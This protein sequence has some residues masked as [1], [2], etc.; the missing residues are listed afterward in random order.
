MERLVTRYMLLAG[1]REK[2][3]P[4]GQSSSTRIGELKLDLDLDVEVLSLGLVLIPLHL[5]QSWIGRPKIPPRRRHTLDTP[6]DESEN[7]SKIKQ[8]PLDKV[9]ANIEGIWRKQIRWR[10]KGE[11]VSSFIPARATWAG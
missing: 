11:K 9:V 1:R 10:R 7:W 8:V 2:E 4:I 6:D 5:T 3:R